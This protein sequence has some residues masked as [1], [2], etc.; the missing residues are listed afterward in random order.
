MYIPHSKPFLDNSD[1]LS[2]KK[3][4]ESAYLSS[5]TVSEKFSTYISALFGRNYAVPTQSGTDAVTLALSALQPEQNDKIAVPAYVCSAL[6]DALK[7][8]SLIPVPV[9]ISKST[10]AIDCNTVNEQAGTFFAV[11][12]AHLFGIP[13]PLHKIQHNRLIED[14]AQTL[15][16]ETENIKTGTTGIITICSFYATKLLTTGHGGAVVTDSFDLFNRMSKNID[17]DNNSEWTPHFHFQM[18]DYNAALGLS[19]IQKLDFFLRKRRDIA[20]RYHKALGAEKDFNSKESY[21]RFIVIAEKGADDLINKFNSSGIEAK[22]PVFK[23]IHR[24]LN[25]PVK[26]FPNTEWAYSHVVSVPLYPA[27]TELEIEFI[28]NFLEKHKNEMRCRTSA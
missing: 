21:S 20:L 4:L 10:L 5:G 22:R 24:Y 9:D 17:H 1:M 6:L 27:M 8:N 16:A 18:S 19:Q 12:G 14:C 23:P 3:V 28:E 11:I 2:V 25:L 13:A 26:N 7:L 15:N